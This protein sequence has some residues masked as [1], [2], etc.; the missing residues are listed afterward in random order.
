MTRYAAIEGGGTKWVAAICEG[1]PWNIVEKAE[2]ETVS[3]PS[4]TLTNVKNWLLTKSFDSIGVASFGPIDANQKSDKYG[5][6]TS[7]P[8]VG[9]RD[10]DVLRLLGV[11]D[12]FKTKPFLFDTDVNAPALAEY[13]YGLKLNENGKST[14]SSCA[15]ITIGTGVGVG[16]IINQQSVKGLLHP[17]AGH[18]S[19]RPCSGDELYEG[20]CPF[21]GTC[22]EG[23][24]SIG[25]LAKRLN[26]K[27]SE[28]PSIPDDHEVWDKCS[29]YIAQLCLNLTLIASPERIS[30]GG[31]VLKR[32]SLFPRIRAHFIR[33]LNEYVQHPLLTSGN[34]DTYICEP[35]WKDEAG[36]VGAAYLALVALEN[37]RN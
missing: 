6:I 19:V 11:Y 34:I 35:V 28:L 25:S 8:K 17:E 2:F 9:W 26:C 29:Y 5:F 13:K 23:M 14:Q 31:G 32:S 37:G 1:E 4:E 20:S 3:N 12:E 10:T 22:I 15:Y 24:C 33:L 36:I 30:I 21:H 7:T 27:K 16:L 18:I